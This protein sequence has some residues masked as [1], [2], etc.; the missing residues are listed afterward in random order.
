MKRV[1]TLIMLAMMVVS[2]FAQE[3]PIENQEEKSAT[4]KVIS[5]YNEHLNYGTVTLLMTIESSFIPF[6]SEVIVPPA[7]YQACNSDNETCC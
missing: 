4:G 2:L 1:F 3:Q 6:P 5:W 7:A